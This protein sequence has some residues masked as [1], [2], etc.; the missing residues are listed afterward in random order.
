VDDAGG[1][2]GEG[3]GVKLRSGLGSN[4]SRVGIGGGGIEPASSSA[5]A[6]A[7]SGDGSAMRT[8]GGGGS[9]IC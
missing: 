7:M 9:N 4:C 2:W 3:M 1:E 6:A 8:T 5:S